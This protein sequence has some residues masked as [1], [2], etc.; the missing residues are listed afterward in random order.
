M[1]LSDESDSRLEQINDLV[2]RL[3]DRTPKSAASPYMAELLISLYK[4][5]ELW[6]FLYQGYY[7]AAIEWNGAGERWK[8][9]EFARLGVELGLIVAG[10]R[11]PMVKG[12]KDLVRSPARHWSWAFRLKGRSDSEDD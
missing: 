12:L 9:M 10:P 5:E 1:A 6:G 2:E 3:S 8:A 11:D 7:Y 4:Q